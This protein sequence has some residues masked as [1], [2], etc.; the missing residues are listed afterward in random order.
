[1][2]VKLDE[3]LDARPATMLRDAGLVAETVGQERLGGIADAG[4]YHHCIQ[5]EL[6]L[7]TQDMD[8]GNPFRFPPQPTAGILVLRSPTQL[9][10]DTAALVQRLI[11]ELGSR[12]PQGELWIVGHAGI[13]IWPSTESRERVKKSNRP[14]TERPVSRSATVSERRIG[15]CVRAAS[16]SFT[17]SECAHR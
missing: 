14:F 6:T 4:L 7:L 12:S 2:R 9:L 3:C 17:N 15:H 1:M 16:N 13:R 11:P 8:F 5:D 10:A